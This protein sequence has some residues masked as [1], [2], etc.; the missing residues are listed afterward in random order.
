MIEKYSKITFK[1]L[2][3][4]PLIFTFFAVD[5]FILPQKKIKDSIAASSK[6]E[7]S[8]RS[9]FG[10]K[11]KE[12]LGYKYYTQKGFEFT[13]NTTYIEENEIELYESYV[14]RN[15]NKVKSNYRDYSNELMSGVNGACLFTA[16]VMIVTAII[17]MLLL[18]YNTNLSEN[19]FHNIILS[20][21]FLTLIFFYFLQIYN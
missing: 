7:I 21:S 3:F 8:R 11:S 6:I 17:S 18:K 9:R 10:G 2:L 15:I 16:L 20:N 14:F 12:F 1:I 13:L 4:I 5:Q 19:G